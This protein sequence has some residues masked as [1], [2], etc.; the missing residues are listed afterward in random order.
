MFVALSRYFSNVHQLII[1]HLLH[2]KFVLSAEDCERSQQ[3]CYLMAFRVKW[4]KQ[5]KEIKYTVYVIVVIAKKNKRVWR[6]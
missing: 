5:D 1:Q 4:R 2:F 6:R 3:K